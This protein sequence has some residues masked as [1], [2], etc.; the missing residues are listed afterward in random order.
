M[1][2]VEKAGAD[3]FDLP[4]PLFDEM[5]A[6]NARG[7]FSPAEAYAI[8]RE[9]LQ[10]RGERIDPNVR[11]R[12]ERGSR[13]TPADY[14]EMVEARQRLVRA[15]DVLMADVD[16]L[17]LP[18]TAICAPKFTEVSTTEGFSQKNMMLL[19]NPALVNFFDLCAISLPIPG[20]IDQV[21][22]M[23]AA[24]NG[25]D[26]KLFSIATAVEQLFAAQS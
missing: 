24:R 8:H 12:I 4:V 1:N 23:L 10:A 16:A 21:G 18:T 9:R 20:T 13:I 2:Q 15:M 7:G 5:M 11:M 14:A 22:L 26:R 25:H 17:M 6:I 3:V 19:R